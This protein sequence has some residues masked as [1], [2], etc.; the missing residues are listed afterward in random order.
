VQNLLIL[1]QCTIFEEREHHERILKKGYDIFLKVIQRKN[2]VY[3]SLV[4]GITAFVK[5]TLKKKIKLSVIPV[6]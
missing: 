1:V 2:S 4:E 3:P 6:H 5:D